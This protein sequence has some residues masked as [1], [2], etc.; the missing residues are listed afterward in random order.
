MWTEHIKKNS[1]QFKNP[2]SLPWQLPTQ[3]G[4]PSCAQT[5]TPPTTLHPHPSAEP[6]IDPNPSNSRPSQDNGEA[7]RA[8]GQQHPD[9]G[10]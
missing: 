7:V 3:L 8:H 6:I 9:N 5:P 1:I 2:S 10:R 4:R